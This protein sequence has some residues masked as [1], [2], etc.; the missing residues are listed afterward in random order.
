[1]PTATAL[2]NVNMYPH[3]I[4][5]SGF[6]NQNKDHKP[7]KREAPIQ[8][9]VASSMRSGT[10]EKSWGGVKAI[11]ASSESTR[12]SKDGEVI[13]ALNSRRKI[14]WQVDIDELPGTSLFAHVMRPTNDSFEPEFKN[15]FVSSRLRELALAVTP[16]S[17]LQNRNLPAEMERIRLPLR[18]SGHE[19]SSCQKLSQVRVCFF[20][21]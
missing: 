18:C 7:N 13:G 12:H 16:T 15:H 5:V 17:S 11:R 2:L 6:Q 10:V 20:L 9:Q 3:I 21:L 14:P 8:Q 4:S 19:S 1:M